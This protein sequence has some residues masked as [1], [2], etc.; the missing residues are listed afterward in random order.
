MWKWH[1]S[2][3]GAS[4]KP[5]KGGQWK[6]L[7][8]RPRP[9]PHSGR[10]NW[11][12]DGWWRGDNVSLTEWMRGFDLT[13]CPW[14]FTN[15]WYV[16]N[17]SGLILV[18]SS[19][20]T[21]CLVWV[22]RGGGMTE[23]GGKKKLFSFLGTPNRRPVEWR[24][25][26][27]WSWRASP[28][29]HKVLARD[30]TDSGAWHRVYS[31]ERHWK[32]QLHQQHHNHSLKVLGLKEQHHH[33]NGRLPSEASGL[34]LA[35]CPLQWWRGQ[36]RRKRDIRTTKNTCSPSGI[37]HLLP[38]SLLAQALIAGLARIK[39]RFVARSRRPSYSCLATPLHNKP[40]KTVTIWGVEEESPGCG[41]GGG[42]GED[43]CRLCSENMLCD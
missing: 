21:P 22:V 35:L 5:I 39:N 24:W 29:T 41:G 6:G 36:R 2:L 23:K 15:S 17:R 13:G 26:Q 12:P 3:C 4:S 30:T 28:R 40:T 8:W 37:R 38:A 43:E 11:R 18:L 32:T 14:S 20:L 7:H 34:M 16:N 19:N 33:H 31:V 10:L 27:L 25:H 42:G 1:Y 9:L